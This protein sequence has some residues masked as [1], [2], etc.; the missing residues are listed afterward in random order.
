[1]LQKFQQLIIENQL[2][3]EGEKVLLAVSGGVDSMVMLNLFSRAGYDFG[4][5]H[6]NFSLRGAASDADE[7]LV[8][9][10]A[11]KYGCPFYSVRFDTRRIAD[12]RN[13]SIQ[14]AARDLRYEWFEQIAQQHGFQK[15]A[16][17]HHLD[18]SIETFHLNAARGS[19]IRGLCGIPAK[20]GNTVR[21]MLGISRG[22]IEQ[23]ADN[24]F[25][26][27]REDASNAKQ[28]YAR[29]KI[30]HSVLP[31]LES[32]YP[33][34]RKNLA[35]TMQHLQHTEQIYRNAIEQIRQNVLYEDGNTVRLNIEA[36]LNLQPLATYL[37]ELLRPYQ[38]SATDCKNIADSL[39]R[40]TGKQFHSVTHALIKDR[41]Y[42]IINEKNTSTSETQILLLQ[43]PDSTVMLPGN[44]QLTAEI[45]ARMPDF[46]I[47]THAHIACLDAGLLHFPLM[48]R[49][50][51][52][53]DYFYPLGMKQRKKL[54]DFFIDEKMS[55][56]EKEE[57]WIVETASKIAWIVG[58]R[59]DNRFKITS[60]TK[61]IL[62]LKWSEI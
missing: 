47:P 6:C 34:Y 41:K 54:S 14:M 1:M 42:L 57:V 11:K 10:Q 50:W 48:L 52:Q 31:I 7:A 27:Y 51:K 22:E 56:R 35:Q 24:Q 44:T 45:F 9:Q 26:S 15:I 55:L 53:G 12:K 28:D 8:S 18:D 60:K 46:Q 25:I 32:M 2:I 30:R 23:Y 4:V 29:N 37:F 49:H 61:K 16:T 39:T 40:Q 62:S 20:N 33:A 43:T 36:L 21:P 38:F 3:T 13:I 17:A 19:G 59:I 58:K 5:A